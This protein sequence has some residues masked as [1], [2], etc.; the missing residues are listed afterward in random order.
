MRGN[1]ARLL[2]PAL[3]VLC[4]VCVVV[5]AA[6]GST[7]RGTTGVRPPS[8]TLLD[9]I[10]SLGFVAVLAGAV[11]F[12]Y[13]LTQRKATTA[14]ALFAIVVA[15]RGQ[16]APTSDF[17]RPD[18]V[19]REAASRPRLRAAGAAWPHRGSAGAAA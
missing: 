1:A 15:A 14:A 6:T 4:P 5:I 12:I 10:L 2:L 19:E 11:L 9:T 17:A 16:A 13:D 18:S 3:V 7:S 8:A